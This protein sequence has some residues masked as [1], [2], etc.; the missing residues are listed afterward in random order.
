LRID[1]AM[2]LAPGSGA[3]ADVPEGPRAQVRP[4]GPCRRVTSPW[5]APC[6]PSAG[7][8]RAFVRTTSGLE[9]Y[10]F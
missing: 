10:L 6:A 9:G 3:K 1:G 2:W 7:L 4:F 5:R 8:Q